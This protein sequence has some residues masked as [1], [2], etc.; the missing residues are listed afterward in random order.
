MRVL[1]FITE[2]KTQTALIIGAYIAIYIL[3]MQYSVLVKSTVKC[4][5]FTFG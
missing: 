2:T 4:L 3:K 5:N 1:R